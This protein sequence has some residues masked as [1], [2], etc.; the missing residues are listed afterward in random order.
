MNS[1]HNK[2]AFLLAASFLAGFF[3]IVASSDNLGDP[4]VYF[5]ALLGGLGAAGLLKTPLPEEKI[6]E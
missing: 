1:F 6:H 5:R 3:G 2:P 4:H